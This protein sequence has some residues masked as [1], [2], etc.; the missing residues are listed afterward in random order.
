MLAP[1]HRTPLGLPAQEW[2]LGFRKEKKCRH[3]A[4][5]RRRKQKITAALLPGEPWANLRASG[6]R[7]GDD[8][9]PLGS[10]RKWTWPPLTPPQTHGPHRLRL[11]PGLNAR[12]TSVGR[13]PCQVPQP[14]RLWPVLAEGITDRPRRGCTGLSAL[15][16][17]DMLPVL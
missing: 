3:F 2:Q 8:R 7:R 12:Q 1:P 17:T 11:S 4:K 16:S 10:R 14:M 13:H 9:R 15:K 5:K 6:S